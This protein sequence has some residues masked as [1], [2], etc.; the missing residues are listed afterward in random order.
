ML[1]PRR[2]TLAA[3]PRHHE[4][5]AELR[6]VAEREDVDDVG[7]LDR[8]DG[9]R[10]AH[11]PGDDLLAG[12]ESR[13]EHLDRDLLADRRVDPAVDDPHPTATEELAHLVLPG[14]RPDGH[15]ACI[16]G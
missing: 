12:R 9:A 2:Q 8:V 7:V 16:G 10:L 6:A 4:V 1:D 15:A 3:Q 14:A 13:V 5:V 11:E